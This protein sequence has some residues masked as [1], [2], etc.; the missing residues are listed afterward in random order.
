M[1]VRA[2]PGRWRTRAFARTV[3]LA[4]IVEPNPCLHVALEPCWCRLEGAVPAPLAPI[5]L[6]ESHVFPAKGARHR[7]P[8]LPPRFVPLAPRDLSRLPPLPLRALP[9]H[10]ARRLVAS[11]RT[12]TPQH[13]RL[14]IRAVCLPVAKVQRPLRLCL[15]GSLL[16]SS[17]PLSS[18]PSSFCFLSAVKRVATS[19]MFL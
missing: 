18:F 13:Q 2:R 1:E 3:L 4:K 7:A 9:A 15:V 17:L 11:R 19:P 12:P 5:R 10:H 16:G 14:R 8:Q 6:L